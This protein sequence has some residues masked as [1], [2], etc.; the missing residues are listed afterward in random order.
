MHGKKWPSS[1]RHRRPCYVSMAPDGS[2]GDCPYRTLGANPGPR[3]H[4][5][6]DYQT[7]SKSTPCHG[8]KAQPFPPCFPLKRMLWS[9][10]YF[11][12]SKLHVIGHFQY[13]LH[14]DLLPPRKAAG[15]MKTLKSLSTLNGKEIGSKWKNTIFPNTPNC[16]IAS[17]FFAVI[18]V[19]LKTISPIYKNIKDL[20]IDLTKWKTCIPKMKIFHSHGLGKYC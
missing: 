16:N 15:L 2:I 19:E 8:V 11:Y 1:P 4:T 6:W 13:S 12:S 10:H 14:C 20:K 7:L 3:A 9:N 17:F 18:S 5:H